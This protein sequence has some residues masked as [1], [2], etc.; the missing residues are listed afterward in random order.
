MVVQT[1]VSLTPQIVADIVTKCTGLDANDAYTLVMY[2]ALTYIIDK[3]D[4]CPLL[5]L[6]GF[7]N[8]GKSTALQIAADL[9]NTPFGPTDNS[10]SA[11]LRDDMMNHKVLM[12][13]EGDKSLDES[14]F[15]ARYDSF[16]RHAIKRNIGSGAYVQGRPEPL[17][18][19]TFIHKRHVILDAAYES[20]CIILNTAYKDPK[21]IIAYT[22]G[23]V[24]PLAIVLQTTLL[25]F[26]YHSIT[27]MANSR[28]GYN[29]GLL[30][31]AASLFPVNPT[32]TKYVDE[33]T[34]R[35]L[36]DI[37]EGQQ[38]EPLVLVWD[39]IAAN[40]ITPQGQLRDTRANLQSIVEVLENG[41]NNITSRQVGK[42]IRQLGFTMQKSNGLYYVSVINAQ[43]LARA[44]KKVG[45][46]DS[47]IS[48]NA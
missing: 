48:S 34:D 18:G 24:T 28:P 47:F 19:A 43:T 12:V 42:L 6:E 46:R 29:W 39:A 3:L 20:R 15:P 17:F 26:P 23:T 16:E 2:T 36:L 1:Q 37:Q 21:S 11:S 25:N 30:K 27:A 8:T 40:L 4:R 41:K 13:G 10:T 14:L 45:I 38:Y 35:A 5:I 32:W 22:K 44:G 9:S 7:F 31:L 33:R